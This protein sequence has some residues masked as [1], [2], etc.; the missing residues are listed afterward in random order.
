MLQH[1]YES[2]LAQIKPQRKGMEQK[3]TKPAKEEFKVI[4]CDFKEYFIFAALHIKVFTPV[5]LLVN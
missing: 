4:G 2:R 1:L 5:Y 3:N